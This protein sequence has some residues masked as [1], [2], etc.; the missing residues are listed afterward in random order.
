VTGT[1]FEDPN[2]DGN[3]A[4]GTVPAGPTAWTIRAYTDVATPVLVTSTT[5]NTTTGAYSLTL[6]PGNYIICEVPQAAWFQSAPANTNCS[7]IAGVSAGG[8]KV[9]VTSGSSAT[10]KDFGNYRQGSVTGTKFEDPNADGNL[11][12]GTVPAGPTA[13]SI[14]AYRDNGAGGGT[15]GDGILQAGETSIAGTTTTSTTTGAYSLTLD[16]GSYVLCEVVQANW[17]QSAPANTKCTAISGV[18]AG[19]QAVAV[20]SGSSATNRD[21]GNY[22]DAT[23]NVTKYL[24]KNASGGRDAGEPGLPGWT[25]WID[26]N[27]DGVKDAGEPSAV[28]DATGLASFTVT[29]GSSRRVCEVLTATYHNSDPGP[30]GND[31]AD[32]CKLV[33]A[34]DLESGET[35]SVLFGNYQDA[36][37]SG[38]KFE[39]QNANGVKDPA[40][41]GLGGWRIYVDYN[42]NSG[43]D[44]STEPSA[45]TAADG[46]YTISGVRPGTYKVREVGQTDWTCSYPNPGSTA[47]KVST[48]CSYSVTLTSGGSTSSKDFGNWAK[49]T[50]SGIKFED[51]NGD[52]VRDPDGIDNIPGNTDDE[53]GLGQWTIKAFVDDGNGT[54]SASEGA[55]VPA[56]TTTTAANGTYTLALNPGIYVICEVVTTD[57]AQTK[58]AGTAC[59]NATQGGAFYGPGGYAVI[60]VSSGSIPAKDFGNVRLTS[61]LPGTPS[62]ITDSAFLLKD[63]LSPW[64]ITDFEILLGGKDNTIVATNPGQFYYH[65]RVTN[66]LASAA[67]VDFAI[68]WPCQFMTQTGNQGNPLHAYVQ[69]ASDPANTWRDWTPQSNNVVIVNQ[70]VANCPKSTSGGPPGSA[71]MTVNNVPAGARVWVTVHLDY[72]LKGTQAPSATFGNPPILYTPFASTATI[73]VDGIPVGFSSSSTSLLGRGKKVTV[74]YGTVSNASGD[75]VD[76]T[77]I[78]LTQ[79]GNSAFTQTGADGTYVFYDQQNCTPADG[80]DGGCT[81]ASTSVFTFANGTANTTLTLLGSAPCVPIGPTLP[82]TPPPSPAYPTG[83]IKATVTGGPTQTFT[84][85]TTP[86]YGVSPTFGVAKGS[87]YN[88]DW[89]VS[90]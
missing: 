15:A 20:T 16:P 4:D 29:P 48:D 46:T 37:V 64:T 62:T 61:G 8:H 67:S 88:R 72:S 77:W 28:T 68:S 47:P 85:P 1:K 35:A 34:A 52:G 78:R 75:P 40:E 33:A 44:T 87:A 6:S 27:G 59:Q 9:T 82:C 49:G 71:T 43:F 60:V 3:L 21:F 41:P 89:K 80:L 2:A 51:K 11:A 39:D 69:F 14:R 22:Q 66:G 57:W 19:G 50:V 76:N 53:A 17:F 31:A 24:D 79:G 5:T 73:K 18:G 65:Q 32:H 54:L 86:S 45:I 23:I 25:F 36:S 83:T 7:A 38:V 13:W 84:S 81:G 58:P 42:G 70:P 26:T 63:D 90:P 55:A 30:A 74:V 10:A 12:D 56:A